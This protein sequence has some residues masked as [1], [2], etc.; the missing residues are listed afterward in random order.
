MKYDVVIA[1]IFELLIAD[2]MLQ[3]YRQLSFYLLLSI[4][5]C[6]GIGTIYVL[7]LWSPPSQKNGKIGTSNS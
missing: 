7:Y 3:V 5:L 1:Y 4:S 2:A 6:I